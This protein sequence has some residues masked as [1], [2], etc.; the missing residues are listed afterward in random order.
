MTGI[1]P[2]DHPIQL[3]E[4]G[5]QMTFFGFPF[6]PTIGGTPDEIKKHMETLVRAYNKKLELYIVNPNALDFIAPDTVDTSDILHIH[7][8]SC[9]SMLLFLG[10]KIGTMF[11][12]ENRIEEA[13]KFSKVVQQHL[14]N[15]IAENSL[16]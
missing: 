2:P 16:F 13:K 5:N 9:E 3:N 11:H 7:S 4:K 14:Q 6:G 12:G 1:N 10:A 15:Y 8:D